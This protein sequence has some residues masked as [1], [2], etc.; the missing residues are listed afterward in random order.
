MFN[1]QYHPQILV[2]RAGALGDALLA[3]PIIR[4][5]WQDRHGYCQIDVCT[6]NPEA[7]RN[8]P[9]IRSILRPDQ[10]GIKYDQIVNLDLAYERNPQ[11]HITQAYSLHAF[12][13]DFNYDMQPELHATD[14]EKQKVQAFLTQLG[15]TNFI[16]MHMRQHTW[17]SRNLKPAFWQELVSKT[18]D[19]TDLT[20]VQVG[21]N[22]EIAFE[23]NPRLVNALGK[24]TI[25]ELKE[26]IA[27]SKTFVGMDCATVHVAACTEK[28]LVGFFTS[29]HHEY[30]KPLGKTPFY[31]I[32]ANIDCYGCQKDNPPPCTTYICKRNDAECINRFDT[33]S[34]VEIIKKAVTWS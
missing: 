31:P 28:P 15:T 33:N 21:A 23:G 14:A 4:K 8:N 27:A 18:I 26:L 16:V 29:A 25:H 30:R 22:H 32:A 2:I 17:P 34:V 12:G 24:F 6:E 9:Y 11:M 7:F 19:N 3:T 1:Q 10:L 13:N 20:I 5:L